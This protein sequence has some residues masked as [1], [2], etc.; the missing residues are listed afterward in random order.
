M[1]AGGA[2]M[3]WPGDCEP[4]ESFVPCEQCGCVDLWM[5]MSGGSF[6]W[7]E[8]EP[9]WRCLNCEHP[10][11]ARLWARSAAEL[12]LTYESGTESNP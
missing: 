8:I 9:I 3:I 6:K 1:V 7:Y 12:R 11:K 4:L 2:S 5:A 10:W